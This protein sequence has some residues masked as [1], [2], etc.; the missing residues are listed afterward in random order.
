MLS[1]G[2]PEEGRGEWGEEGG[3][4]KGGREGSTHSNPPPFVSHVNHGSERV[5]PPRATCSFLGLGVQ[6]EP[7]SSAQNPGY[8]WGPKSFRSRPPAVT[9]GKGWSS[10]AHAPQTLSA[11]RIDTS[12]TP[13]AIRQECVAAVV[14]NKIKIHL[15]VMLNL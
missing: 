12:H 6:S 13:V 15:K 3:R 8:S 5:P 10:S 2:V 4:K 11:D 9:R 1:A 14:I 7:P